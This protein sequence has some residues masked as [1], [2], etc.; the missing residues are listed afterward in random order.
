MSRCSP[1]RWRWS[2]LTAWAAASRAGR[3]RTVDVLAVG[4]TPGPGR[5]QWAARLTARLPLPRPVTL[6]LAHPF[7]RVRPVGHDRRGD[8]VRRRRRHLR[9]RAGRV[10]EPGPGHGEPRRRG[11][12]PGPPHVRTA[13]RGGDPSVAVAGPPPAPDP[14]AVVK[15]I[16]AQAGTGGYSGVAQ[17]EVTVAG[18]TERRRDASPSPATTPRTATEM[19]SGTLVHPG[20]RDRRGDS[21]S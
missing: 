13:A 1:G 11:R 6:G 21:R 7:A 19:V 17:T 18:L 9:R 4:R 20:R 5:G 10:V 3:L 14:V 2:P 8:R 16:T 12:P 15:A